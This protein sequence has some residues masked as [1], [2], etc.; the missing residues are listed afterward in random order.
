MNIKGPQYET[1][2]ETDAVAWI[3]RQAGKEMKR[4]VFPTRPCLNYYISRDGLL[5]GC[6][7]MLFKKKYVAYMCHPKPNQKADGIIYDL[8]SPD[9]SRHKL[10][11]RLIWC[12]WVLGYWSEKVK[13]RYR[14]GDP[15]HLELDNLVEL[16]NDLKIRD[17]HAETMHQYEDIYRREFKMIV[18]DVRYKMNIEEEDAKDAVQEAY[19]AITATMTA[20]WSISVQTGWSMR[21][22]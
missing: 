22:R 1:Q 8:S 11:A 10:A 17:E 7:H 16:N 12:T 18:H 13:V 21:R 15:N 2:T 5:F 9:G 14:D 20:G 3:T 19:I 6:R 4:C